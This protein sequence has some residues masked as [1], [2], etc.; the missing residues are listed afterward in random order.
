MAACVRSAWLTLGTLNVA[1]EDE[2]LGYF[3]TELD[4]GYPEVREVVSNRPDQNGIDD[5]TRLFGK[6]VVSANITALAGAG[7]RLDTIPSL[8]APFMLP[9]VRPV[10][11]YVMDRPDVG[12]RTMTLRAADFS[13]PISGTDERTIQLQWVSSDTAALDVT[14]R[15]ATAYAGS[16]VGSGRVYPLTFNRTYPTGGQAATDGVIEPHGDVAIRPIVQI[17]GPITQ[18]AVTFTAIGDGQDA[19]SDLRFK[20]ATVVD[21][22][23]FIEVNTQ[24]KTVR[25]DGDRN[26]NR[27]TSLD[28]QTSTWPVIRPVPPAEAGM[29]VSVAGTSTNYISQVIVLWQDRYLT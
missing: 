6:R 1:L 19:R 17:W 11:H 27:S 16:S 26:Q 14:V 21:A 18:P 12:E 13:A 7:A 25:L 24:T 23:H 10:L 3:C 15:S 8:F 4:L 9:D 28:W 29:T 20:A 22:G 2:D 5:R